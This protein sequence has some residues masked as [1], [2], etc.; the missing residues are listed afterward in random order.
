ML[1]RGVRRPE[2]GVHKRYLEF[3]I[4]LVQ[5]T[6]EP[7]RN[8]LLAADF[9]VANSAVTDTR[10]SRCRCQ[11]VHI[12]LAINNEHRTAV[13]GV[14]LVVA[15]QG[16]V[17]KSLGYSLRVRFACAGS[18][19]EIGVLHIHLGRLMW[20]LL[21]LRV[22]HVEYAGIFEILNVVERSRTRTLNGLRDTTHIEATR[23]VLQHD[24]QQLSQ[25]R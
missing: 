24:M 6:E 25:L 7:E 1:I 15:M 11:G 23:R 16:S 5:E 9:E 10:L 14:D 12:V 20:E 22:K 8:V 2:T 17:E 3:G 13:S 19:A 4:Y 21:T 18:V